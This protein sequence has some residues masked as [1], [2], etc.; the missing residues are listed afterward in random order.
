[1]LVAAYL[2]YLIWR[3]VIILLFLQKCFCPDMVC[4]KGNCPGFA[5]VFQDAV[6]FVFPH[7]LCFKPGT[8]VLLSLNRRLEVVD[9][10]IKWSVWFHHGLKTFISV[11]FINI[12]WISLSWNL[13]V[14]VHSRFH[15][16]DIARVV[17]LFAL[18]LS[19]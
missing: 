17:S 19:L 18:S 15:W 8:F 12:H 13:F 4:F 6:Q 11:Q 7:R 1:M 16:P 3:D 14:F 9:H 10:K 5:H 2:H